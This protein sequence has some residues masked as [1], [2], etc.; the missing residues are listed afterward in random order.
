MR[1]RVLTAFLVLWIGGVALSQSAA[2]QQPELVTADHTEIL[3][4][5]KQNDATVTVVNFW[6]TW[7]VPCIEEFPAFMKLDRT[8]DERGVEVIFVSTDF[9]DEKDAAREFLAEQGL[10]ETSYLKEGKTTPF[11]NAFHEDWTGAI[12][13]TFIYD[14]EGTLI[15]FWE[16]KTDFESLKSRVESA[17]NGTETG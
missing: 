5:I 16:G 7:C 11:V 1:S 13:A 14:A 2:A 8:L 15:E 6:A 9:P 4:V 3:N 12:P 10:S 17:L